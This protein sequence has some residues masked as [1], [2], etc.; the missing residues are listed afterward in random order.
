M[1]L[2]TK[3]NDLLSSTYCTAHFVGFAVSK[4]IALPFFDKYLNC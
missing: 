4:F 2:F 1:L 3:F